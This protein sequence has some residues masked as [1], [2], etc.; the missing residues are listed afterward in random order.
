MHLVTNSKAA[1]REAVTR[2]SE[3][4]SALEWAMPLIEATLAK[5]TL[6]L[7]Q[8]HAWEEFAKTRDRTPEAMQRER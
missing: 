2:K 6:D 1:L 4:L 7:Q 5:R 3:R 8:R